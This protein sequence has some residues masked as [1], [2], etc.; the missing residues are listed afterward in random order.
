M[1]D[2]VLP[3]VLVPAAVE[4][5]LVDNAVVLNSP[6]NGV[7]RT[8]QTSGT[9][10]AV[11]LR[12]DAVTGDRRNLLMSLL[13]SLRGR[14]G[15][16]WIRDDST[17]TRGAMSVA[18][19]FLNTNL[20]AL[21]GWN[22]YAQFTAS[23]RNNALRAIRVD[24]ANTAYPFYHG[25][26]N[27]PQYQPFA[28]RAVVRSNPP[29]RV[30]VYEFGSDIGQTVGSFSTIASGSGHGVAYGTP[31]LAPSFW[32]LGTFSAVTGKA[33]DTI[34]LL[35]ASGARCLLVDNGSNTATFSDQVDNAAWTKNNCTVP[36]TTDLAPDN[37]SDA[38]RVREA[39]DVA[40]AHFVDRTIT[41]TSA[42]RDLCTFGYFK[43]GAG[44]RDI[45]ILAGS[46]G[47]NYSQV[48]FDL[49]A[50]TFGTILNNGTTTNGRAFM[51]D[52]GNGWWFCAIVSFNAASTTQYFQALLVNAGSS[53]YNG[54][55]SAGVDFW[56][57]G[58]AV[59]SVPGRGGI[60]TTTTANATGISQ[61]GSSLS[62]KGGP[63]SID[64]ALVAGDMAE[65]ITSAKVAE[66]TSQLVRLT[67]DL[68]IDAAGCGT[69]QFEQPLRTPPIEDAPVIVCKPMM[70]CILA[71]A[72]LGV[73]TERGLVSD[74]V[75]ELIEDTTT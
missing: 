44:T 2:F 10:W 43:R 8:S 41:R 45:R 68:D 67:A 62:I 40:Q 5:R 46:T 72:E 54:D 37:F 50:G 36:V 64:G 47:T 75:L 27:F 51:A 3:S 60:E 26:E 15:R 33:G 34:D 32:T 71:S 74:F 48:T 55:G 7:T 21:T 16:L 1:T 17:I 69:M 14:E 65:I 9:R 38:R 11:Q 42:A 22:T 12:F 39:S 57:I 49:N 18:E 20:D 73:A 28:C 19:L 31:Y 52:A 58:C 35:Y 30:D 59:G 6:L 25:S 70:R 4:W 66:C 23:V 53:V 29:N 13:A 61:S 24:G 63:A 56:R